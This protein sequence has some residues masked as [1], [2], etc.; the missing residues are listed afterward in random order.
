MSSGKAAQA[1]DAD[2]ALFPDFEFQAAGAAGAGAAAYNLAAD[3]GGMGFIE[4]HRAE[5]MISVLINTHMLM[6]ARDEEVFYPTHGSPIANPKDWLSQLGIWLLDAHARS[7][8]HD[9]EFQ[10]LLG[11]LDE[12]D[13]IIRG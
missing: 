8:R 5:C 10:L 4:T 1:V 12:R 6:A 7:G 11:R 3:M 13:Y 2:S 9:R